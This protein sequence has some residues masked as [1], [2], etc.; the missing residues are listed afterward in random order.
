[1][2]SVFF[3]RGGSDDDRRM[4]VYRGDIYVI[5]PNKYSTALIELAKGMVEEALFPDDPQ[6]VHEHKT[7][8]ELATLLAKVKPAFIHH[9]ECKCI[10]PDLLEH[11][12]C[13]PQETYFDV[14]RL[15][16]AYPT[17]HLTSGIA[18]AFHAHRDVWYSAP[19]CQLNWW[20][21]IYPLSQNNCLA[22]Y[23]KYFEIPVKNSSQNYNYYEWNAKSRSS[24]S[25]H[26]RED[27]REQPKLQEELDMTD[28]RIVPPPGSM[29]IFS[30]AHLHATVENTSGIARY[31]IDFRTIHGGD[32][33]NKVG[34][35]NLDSRCT[36]TTMRDYLRCSDQ[37]HLPEDIISEYNDGTELAGGLLNYN[38]ELEESKV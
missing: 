22:F 27:L 1:M 13:D 23:P 15:R 12:G 25:Q 16:S 34:A 32:A 33:R 28:L 20:L 11:V 6:H 17:G 8:E 29:I 10:I 3:D 38:I 19:M 5:G 21:P 36:G 2:V 30:G 9:P 24:A 26:V 31:S 7:P 14:P 35:P 18:Y 37:C 4:G